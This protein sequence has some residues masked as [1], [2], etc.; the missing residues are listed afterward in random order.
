ML[1]GLNITTI[2]M[3]TRKILVLVEFFH[4]I[5]QQYF[6]LIEAKTENRNLSNGTLNTLAYPHNF[7][8]VIHGILCV[9]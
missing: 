6:L 5:R 3:L 8:N 9:N 7:A 1:H 2:I 4:N